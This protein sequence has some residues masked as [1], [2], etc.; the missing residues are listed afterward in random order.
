MP[1]L[2]GLVPHDFS[3]TTS[4]L[5]IGTLEFVSQPSPVI[6]VTSAQLI[7]EAHTK[8]VVL[9]NGAV[10]NPNQNYRAPKRLKNWTFDVFYYYNPDTFASPGA[11]GR[12]EARWEEIE[13]VIGAQGTL[14]A[15]RGLS[16]GLS[17]QSTVSATALFSSARSSWSGNKYDYS[18][19]QGV[20]LT[21]LIVTFTFELM[22]DFA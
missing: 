10:Y 12:I 9:P 15:Y 5:S 14:R 21:G 20:D 19:G 8:T 4:G 17:G 7:T 3:A 6:G 18:L 13:N 11:D 2:F 1:D 22:T 16:S